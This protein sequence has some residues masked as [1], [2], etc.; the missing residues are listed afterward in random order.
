MDT[1]GIEFKCKDKTEVLSN[2]H[3]RI[4]GGIKTSI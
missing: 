2:K 3:K 1:E 4:I